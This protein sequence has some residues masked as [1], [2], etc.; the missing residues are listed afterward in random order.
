MVK[1]SVQCPKFVI[2][3][4]KNIILYPYSMIFMIEEF[5]A[6]ITACGFF[7][8]ENYILPSWVSYGVS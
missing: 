8:S 7:S 1:N 6:L 4:V 3:W 5:G 2:F